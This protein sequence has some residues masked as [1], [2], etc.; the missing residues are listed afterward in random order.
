MKTLRPYQV[1]AEGSILHEFEQKRSTLL[2]LA[3]GLGKT[4]IASSVIKS[5]QPGR[6]LFLAHTDEL[7][8]QAVASIKEWTGLAVD[9]EKA[10]QYASNDLF[11]R[12]PV[13]VSSIQTQISG[14]KDNRRFKR[15]KPEDF[16]LLICDEAHLSVSPSWRETI[17]HYQQNPKLKLL[18][19]TATP[20]RTDEQAMNQVYESVAM[21]YGILDGIADGW[22]V[23]IVQQ[24]V[25]VKGLDF[26]H[27]K[28]TGGDLNEGQLAEVMERESNVQGICQPVLEAMFGLA[29]KTLHELPPTGWKGFLSGLNLKP[30]RT[31][32]Y[33]VSVAQAEMC[34]NVF[35]RAL[36]DMEWL[37]GK[38]NKQTRRDMIARFGKGA[39][40]GLVNVGCLTHG[41]DN[42]QVEVIAV[43]RATKSASLYTQIIGRGTR[44]L[45][46]IVDGIE[47]AEDRRAAIAG[48]T[49][50]F[51]RVLDFLGN[52]GKHKLITLSDILGGRVSEAAVE[53]TRKLLEDGKPRKILVTM[54][55]SQ[56]ELEKMQREAATRQKELEEARR[57]GILAKADYSLKEV[58]PFSRKILAIGKPISRDGRM[59]SN[60]QAKELRN[61]GVDPRSIKY[62]NGLG[63][64]NNNRDKP[65]PGQRKILE[66]R[67]FSCDGLTRKECSAKI[68]AISEMEGWRKKDAAQQA[69]LAV[70]GKEDDPF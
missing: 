55:N 49:K 50:P 12:A 61:A 44:P 47:K 36:D 34:C 7:I 52:S 66:P 68:D 15:F 19:L 39:T 23:D 14:K 57:R 26:S 48:S 28:T 13:V 41:F 62:R 31:L 35:L 29:P 22:L 2:H 56:L 6:A 32:I 16:S 21:S 54:S 64:I 8:A 63:I 24:F 33:T 59:F 18:G 69:R 58:D 53:R 60:W 42:P 10:S 67:G 9:I 5:M 30:R 65:T 43:A 3:T 17:A 51:I 46:G 20:K 4:A 11:G 27:I 70:A 37:C 45:P 25:P 1:T 40:H 38:T